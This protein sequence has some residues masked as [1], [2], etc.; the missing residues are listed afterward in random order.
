V[1]ELP[2]EDRRRL[3]EL[4]QLHGACL[5]GGVEK[6]YRAQDLR[7]WAG[8]GH[9]PVDVEDG[10]GVRGIIG[11]WAR[12]PRRLGVATSF[13]HAARRYDTSG[14][15]LDD[16]RPFGLLL[17]HPRDAGRA[18][19]VAGGRDELAEERRDLLDRR[20]MQVTRQRLL[21]P[22]LGIPHPR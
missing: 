17:Q 22:R 7:A 6:A 1:K 13:F 5:L 9:P 18:V 2:A 14:R 19:T 12:E 3:L 11:K 4:E 10:N 20:Q 8:Y 16:H 21:S 15:V